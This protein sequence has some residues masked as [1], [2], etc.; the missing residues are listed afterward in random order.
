M[1][2][3]SA[4]NPRGRDTHGPNPERQGHRQ[5]QGRAGRGLRE[6]VDGLGRRL[7]STVPGH[8]QRV[9]LGHDLERRAAA[10]Q[11]PLHAEPGHA[12]LPQPH[13]RVGVAPEG[14]AA[15][16]RHQGRGP[17]HHTPDR[18]L[19][20]RATGGGVLPRRPQGIRR[21]RE[22]LLTAAGRRCR[23]RCC[24]T[25]DP[26]LASDGALRRSTERLAA[27]T[28]DGQIARESYSMTHQVTHRA[29]RPPPVGFSVLRI[30]ALAAVLL[31]APAS[32]A[33]EE[34]KGEVAAI[35][36]CDK[37]LCAI[38]LEKKPKGPDLK[39]AL[40]KTW[41]RSKVKEADNQQMSWGF[42]D[43]RCSIDLDVSRETL[44]TAM[45]ADHVTLRAP[46]HTANCVVEQ[47][48]K[49]EKVTAILAPKIEI[50]NGRAEKIWVRLK[51][52][53]GP[54]S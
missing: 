15:K 16:R 34:Q 9:L 19:R 53:D 7:Q 11:D 17:G 4:S 3:R 54:T 44:V 10:A 38:L 39:C 40:T 1:I 41:D 28:D 31:G 5:P 25:L 12:R 13:A 47:D 2:G 49:P 24:L 46:P 35:K 30:G 36:E 32:M 37:R 52:V 22:G 8:P 50:R 48:G 18:C 21:G 26:D 45:T 29:G 33:L 43:A 27:S 42:G 14:R 51:R 6:Q 20:R 23:R